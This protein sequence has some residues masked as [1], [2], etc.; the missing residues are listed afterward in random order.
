MQLQLIDYKVKA[1]VICPGPIATNIYNSSR[2]S[3]RKPIPDSIVAYTQTDE[4]EEKYQKNVAYIQGQG[5]PIETAVDIIIKGIEADHFY[6]Y[7]H[8]EV[9]YLFELRTKHIFD[10]TRPT[11]QTIYPGG[12]PM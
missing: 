9:K 6:I 2:N 3:E 5:L 1:F 12:A 8:P 11:V 4:Y 10:C 7:T